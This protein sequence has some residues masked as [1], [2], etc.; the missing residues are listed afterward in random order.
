MKIWVTRT[1]PGASSLGEALR[2]RGFDVLTAP[3]LAIRPKVFDH[4]AGQY[5]YGVFLSVHGVR[6]AAAALANALSTL[7]AVGRSTRAALGE[8]GLGAIAPAIESSEGLLAALPDPQGK[9]ILIVTGAGGRNLLPDV[10]TDRG[11]E[12]TRLDVYV[13]YPLAPAIEP[14]RLDAIVVSSGD[15]LRRAAQLWF[16]AG[17]GA[18]VPV[19]APSARIVS[20]GRDAGLQSLHDCGGAGAE[21]VLGT[22]QRLGMDKQRG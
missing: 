22:L 13:R 18:D 1:E 11:A 5:D 10:L 14:A 8:L 3:V 12:V 9:R 15:G 20:L 19:L 21:A 16:A 4:P 6:I 2:N 7:Y 17:G